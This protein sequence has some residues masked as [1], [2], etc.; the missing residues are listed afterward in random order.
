[1]TSTGSGA[2]ACPHADTTPLQRHGPHAHGS[3]CPGQCQWPPDPTR[4]PRASVR[5]GR[6]GGHCRGGTYPRR[7]TRDG[8]NFKLKAARPPPGGLYQPEPRYHWRRPADAAECHWQC[9]SHGGWSRSS[10]PQAGTQ[11][12][13]HWQLTSIQ[14]RYG[15]GRVVSRRKSRTMRAKRKTLES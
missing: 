4:K 5:L 9:A 2:L 1:V 3:P 13:W 12:D 8:D 11:P 6:G 10:L 14:V 15:P 7:V